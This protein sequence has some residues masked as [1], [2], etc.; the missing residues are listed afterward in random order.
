ML[1]CAVWAKINHLGPKL[2]TPS[3]SRN[4]TVTHCLQMLGTTSGHPATWNDKTIILCDEL[5]RGV[6]EGK[7]F[8]D[9]EFILLEC[10][11]SD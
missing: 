10:D 9:G 8:D 3:H 11:A 2:K 7:L 4:A 6:H 5:I 1:S